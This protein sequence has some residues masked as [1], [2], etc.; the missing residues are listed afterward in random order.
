MSLAWTSKLALAASL[1]ILPA[2]GWAQSVNISYLTHWSP[3]TVALLETA[4][5]D[6]AKT[7]P[8]VS[9]TVRAV[10][11]GDLLTTLRSQGAARTVLRSAAST[12][13]GCLS[14]PATSSSRPPPTPSPKRSREHGR[15]AW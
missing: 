10:P 15:L 7:N 1:A 2:S 5:K 4:A 11:F 14:S 9:V 12:I 6:Y 3:E 8:D 13:S